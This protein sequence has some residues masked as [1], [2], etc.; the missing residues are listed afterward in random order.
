MKTRFLY[1]WILLLLL[2]ACVPQK[3]IVYFQ[4]NAEKAAYEYSIKRK[5]IIIAPA[6]VLYIT[7]NSLDQAGYNFFNQEKQ[8]VTSI[9]EQSLGILGY[10]VNDSGAVN[11]PLLGPVVVKGLTL[12]QASKLL[13]AGFKGILNNPIVSVRF[14]NNSV[15]ILGDVLRPGT[16]T[17][18]KEQLSIFRALGLAGDIAEYGNRRRVA[19]IREEDKMIHK[20]YLD[21]TNEAIFTSDYYWLKPNDVVYV[22]PLRIRRFGMKEYPFA[23]VISAVSSVFLILYYLK[24]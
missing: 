2:G 24:R 20:Y 6:D 1:V 3:H 10:T 21:L 14:V 11:I 17:Y 19:I 15:T 23:L 22:E 12:D 16:Y 8:N 13:V 18:T 7:V 9:T 4:S 5:N